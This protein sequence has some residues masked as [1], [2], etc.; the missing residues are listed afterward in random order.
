M[1]PIRAG[2]FAI[3]ALSALAAARGA[4]VDDAGPNPALEQE[5]AALVSALKTARGGNADIAALTA[6]MHDI[7]ADPNFFR[8][9]DAERHRAFLL[10]GACLFDSKKHEEASNPLKIASEMAAAGA[11]DWDLRLENDFAQGDNVD[12]ARAMTRLAR[13]WPEKI[14]DY[15]DRAVFQVAYAVQNA[16]ADPKIGEDLLTAL[17]DMHWKPKKSFNLPDGLWSKLMQIRLD[18]G[19]SAGAAKIAAE[20][21]DPDVMI[22]MRAD[23]RFDAIVQA[24]PAQFD[25]MH[26]YA[27]ELARLKAASAAAPDKLEGVIAVASILHRLKRPREGL[28]LLDEALDKLQAKKDAFSDADE[29]R[30]WL[31]DERSRLLFQLGR[32]DEAVAVL[33]KGAALPENGTIN[34]SQA[35]NLAEAYNTVGQ[36]K[37]AL[38]AVAGIDAPM[39]SPYGRVAALNARACAYYTLGEQDQ[40]AKVLDELKLHK[41]DGP[42]PYLSAMLCTGNEQAAAAQVIAQLN[43]PETRLGMLF[44]VQT[45][46]PDPHPTKRARQTHALWLSL[47]ERSDVAAAIAAVGRIESYAIF[48]PSY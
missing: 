42:G 7:I 10:Y 18:R 34:V 17:F 1:N 32:D 5:R 6:T 44:L 20:I 29:K 22:Q 47:L 36:A 48:S 35:I 39:V 11:A 9:S 14:A 24:A 38:A 25:V 16:G 3:A 37:E 43:D 13:S 12:A 27:E 8:L 31:F 15:E 23:R 26:A 28:A 41:D 46:D 4:P 19:D 33:A 2:I 45:Y 30:N 21:R 40:L